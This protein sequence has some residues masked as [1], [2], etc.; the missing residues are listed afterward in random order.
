M[1]KEKLTLEQKLYQFRMREKIRLD[2]LTSFSPWI[3]PLIPAAISYFDFTS[4]MTFGGEIPDVVLNILAI[5]VSVII[6]LMG[7]TTGHTLA[8]Y[9]AHNAKRDKRRSDNKIS[10]LPTIMAFGLYLFLVI[11]LNVVLPWSEISQSE[12]LTRLAL[13]LMTISSIITIAVRSIYNDIVHEGE[14]R[15]TDRK[16]KKEKQP[17]TDP[18]PREQIEQADNGLTTKEKLELF[19]DDNDLDLSQ[20]GGGKEYSPR[21]IAEIIN[22]K[23]NTV[24]VALSRMKKE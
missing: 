1:A 20:I 6:E 16:Q 18:I 9:A 12:A 23:P 21:H 11:T 8:V 22:E 2:Y 14:V 24:R 7:L 13:V 15:K 4:F 17:K 19:M 10:L 5:L 3:A